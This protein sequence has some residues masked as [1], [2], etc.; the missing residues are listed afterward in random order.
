MATLIPLDPSR[1]TQYTSGTPELTEHMSK[2]KGLWE[3]FIKRQ[4]FPR[5][6]LRPAIL[7]SWQR[8]LNYE[9]SPDGTSP[10]FLNPQE[11]KDRIKM[12][13]ECIDALEPVV[14]SVDDLIECSNHLVALVDPE[15]FV[16]R[17][18]GNQ[19]IQDMLSR[20]NFGVGANWNERFAG[21]TAV[22]IAL[23]TRQPT[24]VFHAEHYCQKLHQFSCTAV[25]IFDPLTKDIIGVLNFVAYIQDHQPHSMGMAMQMAK[26]IELEIYRSRKE[27]DELFR[28]YSTQLMLD[29]MDRGIIVLDDQRYI[30]RANLKALDFLGV[31]G[32]ELLHKKL[33]DLRILSNWK[34]LERPFFISGKKGTGVRLAHQP[35]VHQ[36]RAIGSLIL[37]EKDNQKRFD[38]DENDPPRPLGQSRAF[39]Q[40]LEYAENAAHFNSNVLILGETGSGKEV[41]AR[42]IHQKSRRKENPFLAINCGCI[43]K[44][45]LGSELFGYEDGAFTGA[46]KKGKPSKFELADG[47]TLL[48][49]EVSEMPHESQVYLLRVIEERAVTRLGGCKSINVD[50]RII[51]AANKNLQEEVEAGRFR[52]DLFFRLNVLRIHL[53]PLKERK[54]DIPL[55]SRHFIE[56]LSESLEKR[57]E[58]FSGESM[59]ALIAYDWPGNIRELR[60]TV[61]Q[62][63]VMCQGDIIQVGDL[64]EHIVRVSRDAPNSRNLKDGARY[65][66]F[67]DAYHQCQG[68]ITQIARL[69]NVSRPTV[70]AWR[71]KYGI[72]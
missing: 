6:E 9:I 48:L 11:L 1:T 62:A 43:P 51:A 24:H 33:N 19:Q 21:T 50:V 40:V 37:L 70:Y 46:R 28:E 42:Y 30:R 47:G 23:K 8:C 56:I 26:C 54:E 2:M 18:Y 63:I 27:R 20:L 49:D 58:G 35:I 31:D 72:A 52:A 67:I 13:Q 15:G 3:S 64:P 38:A 39:R 32:K 14:S 61:E 12:N 53:P 44:D 29:Q 10:P 5:K 16:L 41:L 22:G 68:N 60:N 59:S 65:E 25:P 36:R 45:L 7:N 55:L 71:K 4:L 17:T 57:V 69:L 66:Q 34:S